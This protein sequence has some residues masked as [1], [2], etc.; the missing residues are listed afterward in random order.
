MLKIPKNGSIEHYLAIIGGFVIAGILISNGQTEAGT[1]IAS[2]L[3]GY[4][5]GVKKT[6]YEML[7]KE[8]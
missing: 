3:I 1:A 5:F 2:A 4:A 7:C 8:K 6:E